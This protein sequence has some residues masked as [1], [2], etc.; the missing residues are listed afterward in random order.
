MPELSLEQRVETLFQSALNLTA[1]KPDLAIVERELRQSLARLHQ[2]MRVAIVGLIKAGKSTMM[3]A[4]LGEHLVPT[5]NVEA[6]FNVNVFR[7]GDRP[8]LQ[9]YY[10]DDRTP[11]VK[12]FDELQAFTL[13]AEANRD[14]LRSIKY[15]DVAY[16]NP[17]LHNFNLVD[18]PGM[19]SHYRDDSDNTRQFL[20]LH[21][22]ELS[23]VTQAEAQGADAVMYLFSHSL[24]MEDK[25]I[26]E[27]FQGTGGGQATPINAIGV[28]TKTDIYWSDPH[29]TDPLIAAD[30]ICQRLV[31]HP[32]V[33]N[34]FYTIY[35]VCGHLALGARTLTEQEW[36]ILDR[37]ITIPPDRL[38]SL[39]RNINRF[40]EREYPDVSVAPTERKQLSDRLGQYGVWLAYNLRQSGITDRA[41]LASALLERSGIERLRETIISHFGHRAYLI[42]LSRIL[43]QFKTVYFQNRSKLRGY[44]LQIL[45]EIGGKFEELESQEHGLT[46][47]SI[48]RNFYHQKLTFDEDEAQQLLAVTGEFGTSCGERL[49]LVEQA[50]IPEMLAITSERMRYWHTRSADYFNLDRDTLTAVKT[51]VRSYELIFQRL[52]MAKKYLYF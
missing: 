7:W 41:Q 34:L 26:V 6:T 16:P 19:E 37:L 14:Y 2:P 49:G 3:N 40:N 28:L 33:R 13:R 43:H 32:Q 46:E 21:G 48:L 15:I 9:V 1:G 39:L 47:L 22:Q 25:E 31:H 30:L 38:E 24:A 20:Q 51:M 27:L 4:L 42:K 8:S 17:I 5:G 29:I 36:E 11:E 23:E 50:S 10:K 35:P 45:E 44:Q 18:T 52:Q 12:S